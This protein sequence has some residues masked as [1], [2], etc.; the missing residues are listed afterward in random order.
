MSIRISYTEA[1]K[2]FAELCDEITNDREVAIISRRDSED[3][4][5]VTASELTAL[6]PSEIP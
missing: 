6:L 4:V 5:L 1:K 2:R 3:I